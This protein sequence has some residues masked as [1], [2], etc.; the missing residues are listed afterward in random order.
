MRT[1]ITRPEPTRL[2]GAH[3]LGVLAQTAV[4][5]WR[6]SPPS[7]IPGDRQ[8]PHALWLARA[9]TATR[10]V[11][12]SRSVP[13]DL[14]QSGFNTS[15]GGTPRPALAQAPRCASRSPRLAH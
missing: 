8:D 10:T 6:S 12:A 9:R 7:S 2:A 1:A 4:G 5:A 15:A 3:E 11:A 13:S 14:T